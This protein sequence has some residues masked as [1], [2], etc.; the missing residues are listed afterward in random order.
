MYPMKNRLF[1]LSLLFAVTFA[2]Q[3]P[4]AVHAQEQTSTRNDINAD[5]E[6]A[7]T[8]RKCFRYTH[9]LYEVDSVVTDY[10]F[11]LKMEIDSSGLIAS[12]SHSVGMDT[13]LFGKSYRDFAH[14]VPKDIFKKYGL[15]DISILMPVFIIL[16]PNEKDKFDF[17]RN[18]M[19]IARIWE[20]E[21]DVPSVEYT[22]LYHPL[23]PAFCE[24]HAVFSKP[25]WVNTGVHDKLQ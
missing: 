25:M 10:F 23:L 3:A 2:F 1:F 4:R 22:L 12:V 9:N 19:S 18:G 24:L 14:K 11:S 21:E 5:D 16:R 8:L 6:L 15:R 20:F 7:F 17:G 13:V